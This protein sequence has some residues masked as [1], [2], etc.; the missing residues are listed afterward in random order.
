[1]EGFPFKFY[2]GGM[3]GGWQEGDHCIS[4]ST[5]SHNSLSLLSDQGQT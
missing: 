3:G 5:D 1:M 4:K 2:Y